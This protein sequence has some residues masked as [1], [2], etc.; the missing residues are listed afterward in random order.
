M[1]NGINNKEKLKRR[2]KWKSEYEAVIEE[3][4]KSKEKG[5]PVLVGTTSIENFEKLRNLLCA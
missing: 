1:I 4:R 2:R 5:Q 3:I